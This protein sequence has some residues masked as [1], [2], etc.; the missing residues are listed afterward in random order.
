MFSTDWWYADTQTRK[1]RYR[2][3]I[4]RDWNTHGNCIDSDKGTYLYP[5]LNNDVVSIFLPLQFP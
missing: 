1:K 5:E 2:T 4:R 3:L